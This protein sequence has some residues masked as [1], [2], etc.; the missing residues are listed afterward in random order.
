MFRQWLSNQLPTANTS[1]TPQVGPTASA[2]WAPLPET[3]SRPACISP[4]NGAPE[5][6]KLF[7]TPSAYIITTNTEARLVREGLQIPMSEATVTPLAQETSE[8]DSFS[9]LGT[10][11]G[12]H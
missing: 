12:G 9:E 5:S 8:L 4:D 6:H 7:V 10:M 3:L 1:A 2:I 11:H